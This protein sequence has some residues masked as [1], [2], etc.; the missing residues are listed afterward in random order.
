MVKIGVKKWSKKWSK[1]GQ[2]KVK[3]RSKNGQIRGQKR[4]QKMVKKRS[5]WGP[6]KG[7]KM[8]KKWSKLE[9]VTFWGLNADLRLRSDQ[10]KHEI[11]K[12]PIWFPAKS[13]LPP[14]KVQN[15]SKI[16]NKITKK[17][18]G[19]TLKRS[20]TAWQND[21]KTGIEKSEY[22]KL[23]WR[24]PET[25]RND[26]NHIEYRLDHVKNPPEMAKIP[27]SNF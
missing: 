11:S 12:K 25:A 16:K 5:N 18:T 23:S 1:N 15:R 27:E 3:K 4:V 6:K 19:L 24:R 10:K 26:P 8:V 17:T 21:E 9:K 14:K 2:K 20:K 22:E 7:Q 13:C